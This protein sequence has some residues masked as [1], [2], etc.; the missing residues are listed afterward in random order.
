MKEVTLD[1]KGL[2]WMRLA[3]ARG[4]SGISYHW[5]LVDGNDSIVFAWGC[6]PKCL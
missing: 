5:R 4:G 2:R 6:Y 1:R 3:Y